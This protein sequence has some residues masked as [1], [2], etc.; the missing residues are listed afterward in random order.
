MCTAPT[1]TGCVVPR[2][3]PPQPSEVGARVRTDG[4]VSGIAA[5]ASGDRSGAAMPIVDSAHTTLRLPLA[6]HGA[7]ARVAWRPV[8]V[9]AAGNTRR[10][11]WGGVACVSE[12]RAS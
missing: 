5:A 8:A 6:P 1:Q 4:A 9:D 3:P 7:A 11:D 2:A 12:T 10:G